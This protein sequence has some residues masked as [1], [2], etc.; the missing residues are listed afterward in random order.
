MF[1]I[2]SQEEL[3]LLNTLLEVIN[4]NEVFS[5]QGLHVKHILKEKYPFNV[6]GTGSSMLDAARSDFIN[7]RVYINITSYLVENRFATNSGISPFTD[8]RLSPEG[9]ILWAYG[10]YEKYLKS[11]TAIPMEKIISMIPETMENAFPFGEFCIEPN[12]PNVTVVDINIFT[13]KEEEELKKITD[14][15]DQRNSIRILNEQAFRSHAV[16]EYL[17]KEGFAI[18]RHDI[19]VQ[20]KI[21]RQLTDKGRELKECGSIEAY[22][23]RNKKKLLAAE[24]EAKFAKA[25]LR[26]QDLLNQTL[27]TYTHRQ[28]NVNVWIAISTCVTAILGIFQLS[29]F[30]QKHFFVWL[31]FV[32]FISGLGFGIL[33]LLIVL[34]VRKPNLKTK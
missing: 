11:L 28:Y 3:D 34:L 29:E 2:L 30:Y 17:V 5:I 22:N 33:L 6:G 20:N 15:I 24:T 25:S 7:R 31:P 23:E 21:Y 32:Y 4:P 13:Q 1:T 16:F 8:L 18:N 12:I 14:I 10:N 9:Q 27:H 26:N 19:K